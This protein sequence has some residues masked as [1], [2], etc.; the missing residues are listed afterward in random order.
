MSDYECKH[1]IMNDTKGDL[2]VLA[3]ILSIANMGM[4]VVLYITLQ[5]V[6]MWHG[7]V[8]QD[9]GEDDY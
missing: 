8:A 6:I 5:A 4:L 2:R 1:Q 3:V 9:D 7:G